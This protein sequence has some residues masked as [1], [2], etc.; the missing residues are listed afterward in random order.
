MDWFSSD[1]DIVQVVTL[2]E[3]FQAINEKYIMLP[4]LQRDAIWS[5]GR[6]CALWD[7]IL[8]GYPLP[9]FV[10]VRG[11][12]ESRYFGTPD[13]T[14]GQSLIQNNTYF[15]V[16]DGQQRLDAISAVIGFDPNC[17]A[18]RLWIDLAPNQEIH[19][20]GYK[21]WI[22]SCTK[23][24]PFG[25]RIERGGE[26]D[27][28]ALTDREDG[29]LWQ[30]LQKNS[31]FS[32]KEFYDLPL[33]KTCPYKSGCPLSL[34][35]LLKLVIHENQTD[36]RDI[37]F[38]E[39][40]ASI[41]QVISDNKQTIQEFT[42]NYRDPLEE[43]LTE[44]VHA[45]IGISRYRLVFQ[46]FQQEYE[47]KDDHY[48]LYER[49]GRGGIQ[50][51][52]KQLAVSR[53]LLALGK[54]GNDTI[55]SFQ[56]S[57]VRYMQE[58]E[59]VI[60]GMARVAFSAT[61]SNVLKDDEPEEERNN[62]DLI[63]MTPDRLR[64]I[65][66]DNKRWSQ[67]INK[68]EYYCMPINTHSK[69]PRLQ[70][71]FE[72]MYECLRFDQRENPNGFSLFQL[73]QT[74]RHRE[75][76]SPVTLHPILY[77][78]LECAKG[79]EL[80][81]KIIEDMVRWVLFANGFITNPRHL[82]LNREA[83]RSVQLI[84]RLDF[85][86][87][88]ELVFSDRIGH[89][90]KQ[91][92][93]ELGFAWDK[94]V[95]NEKGEVVQEEHDEC[96]SIPDPEIVTELLLRRLT[97]QNW[98]S[99]KL[100]RFILLWNQR[101]AMEELYG[102]IKYIP[103]LFSKGRPV[104]LDHIVA[105]DSLKNNRGGAC[106]DQTT[107]HEG[108]NIVLKHKAKS[109]PFNTDINEMHRISES[110]FR[111]SFPNCIGNYRYWPKRLNRHDSNSNVSTKFTIKNLLNGIE[112]NPLSCKFDRLDIQSI[113]WTWSAIPYEDKHIWINIHRKE[114]YQPWEKEDIAKFFISVIRREYFLYRN[115][116][117][118]VSST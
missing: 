75:G 14:R 8:R 116:Y 3:A 111:L 45:L 90:G 37:Q 5:E 117:E 11:K 72:D 2:L 84:R 9:S 80:D 47:D 115:A 77:F 27:F 99:S 66:K 68:L 98:P 44:V 13:G 29:V 49:I 56:K 59:D 33:A 102:E 53:L 85:K 31:E 113:I 69:I 62:R 23:I 16:L 51:T 58:T 19:P 91:F 103:A 38:N 30:R 63:D 55:T 76:V 61:D 12:G 71:A 64:R 50:I 112:G 74:D 24:F 32:R 81:L 100:T 87:I 1:S 40:R 15:E 35:E 28:A 86:K 26:H 82:K 10:I 108:I 20:F 94:P 118:F 36:W 48:I 41:K 60:H 18:R 34:D 88:T 114:E 57:E 78:Y 39:L 4:F 6:I 96:K 83:F 97:L 54:A 101:H 105:R 79:A 65:Q 25:F 7:S 67:F 52:Q 89:E 110:I 95:I 106:I 21:Y 92:R 70:K 107:I 42:E 46:M 73:A 109:M 43:T 93:R 22:H 104:D 17:S